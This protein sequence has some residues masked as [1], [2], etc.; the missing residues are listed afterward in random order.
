VSRLRVISIVEGQGEES[1]V[2][3]LLNRL[4]YDGFGGEYLDIL[5]PIRRSRSLL[6]KSEE[7][8][9]AVKLARA[10]LKNAPSEDPELMLILVDADTDPPC[11]L[12]PEW[13]QTAQGAVSDVPISCVFAKV[14]FE[15]WFAGAAESLSAFI[16]VA[17]PSQI[18][19]DPEAAGVGKKWIETRFRGTRYSPTVDQPKLTAAMDLQLCRARCPSFDKLCRELERRL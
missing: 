2:R 3:I 9:K 16:D 18:P 12:A 5:R 7:L 17:D 10:K 8:Q 1:A 6:A 4:W 14:E 15:T 13:L 19:A 11:T